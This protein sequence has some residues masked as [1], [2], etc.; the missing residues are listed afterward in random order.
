VKE[1]LAP[2]TLK[3][4]EDLYA[5]FIEP[6]FGKSKLTD[7]KTHQLTEFLTEL[8]SRLNRNSLN[9]VKSLYSS[10][11]SHAAA[12]GKVPFNPVRDAGSLRKAKAPEQTR[13]YSLLEAE[14]IMNALH[15]DSTA[16]LLFL[17]CAM[18]GLRPSE[19]NGLRW[20]DV[21]FKDRMLHLRQSWVQ[22]ELSEMKNENSQAS[23]PLL[24]PVLRFLEREWLSQEQPSDGWVFPGRNP[25]VP[26]NLKVFVRD[27]II[28]VLQKAD[29]PWFGLYAGRRGAASIL[30]D[31]TGDPIASSL[32]LRH[33]NISTTMTRYIKADRRRLVSG[34]KMLEEKIA[35]KD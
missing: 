15:P 16:Q 22:G 23:I 32:L 34:M 26:V 3:S 19:A 9:H 4:Y 5:R 2:S 18:E 21:D 20:E 33:S 25:K 17:L 6:K 28:K 27:R 31:L 14:Q 24:T 30:T 12:L 10:V 1:N 35:V 29:V 11:F 7:V 8:S 13:A